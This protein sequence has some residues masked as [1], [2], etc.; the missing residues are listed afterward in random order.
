MTYI[1]TTA[2][3]VEHGSSAFAMKIE[4]REILITSKITMIYK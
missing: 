3:K 2:G 4:F 1:I